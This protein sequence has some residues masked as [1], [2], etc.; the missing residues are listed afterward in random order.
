MSELSS[1]PAFAG[2]QNIGSG[3]GVHVALRQ[4]N[5]VS[6]LARGGHAQTVTDKVGIVN[7]ARQS[8]ANGLTA[9]GIGPGR[10]LFLEATP[11]QL[12]PLYSLAS[13]SDHSDGYAVFELW[14]P[15]V[16]EALA[17]GVP[18]DLHPA[19]FTDDVAVTIIAHIGAVVWQSAPD[20]FSIA[21]FRSYAGSFWHWLAA[22]AAEFGL[23]VEGA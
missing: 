13:L 12:V 19:V 17:K 20:R 2:L 9:L 7:A 10:W 18:L 4:R 21:I 15:K 22:S 5:I 11:E 3:G 16:R 1:A 8:G 14:G 6:V 23:T